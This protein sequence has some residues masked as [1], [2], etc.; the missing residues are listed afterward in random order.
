MFEVFN[1]TDEKVDLKDIEALLK[2]SVKF[3]NIENAVFNVIII[4][5]SKI[6]EINREYRG[7]DRSTDVIS[8]ALEDAKDNINV[9]ARI[10]GD[11]YIS[12]DTAR[13]QAYEYYNTEKEEIRF[14]VIHGLLHL[15][16]YDHM[17][18]NDEKEM[19]SLEEEVLC[20][21]DRTRKDKKEKL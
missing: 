5:D 14:L 15:L 1:E 9:P 3:L 8:F 2:K 17:N 21:Y 10:L 16:G 4:D 11:I 12:I 18:A 7:V 6:H 20:N 13:R 19:M